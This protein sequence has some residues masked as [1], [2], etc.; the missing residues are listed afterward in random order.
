ISAA[1]YEVVVVPSRAIFRTRPSLPVPAQSVPSA[2]ESTVHRNGA[3]VSATC[4]VTGP[5]KTRPSLSIERFSTSPLRK[6]ACVD[7]VQK[8]GV[9]ARSTADAAQAATTA[10]PIRLYINVY[11]AGRRDRW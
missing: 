1:S 4:A 7:T 3:E 11:Q 9:E 2:P 6:S 10:T 5:R 8:V